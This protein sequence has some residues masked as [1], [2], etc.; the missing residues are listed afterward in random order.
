M[1]EA[2]FILSP[3]EQQ[4]FSHKGEGG[5]SESA[6]KMSL[7]YDFV[8]L[9]HPKAIYWL[10]KAALNGHTL[11]QYNLGHSYLYEDVVKD[12]VKAKYWLKKAAQKNYTSAILL[13][14]EFDNHRQPHQN[15]T[16]KTAHHSIKE[17]KG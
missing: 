11:A 15:R 10:K 5:D 8:A 17:H 14:K 3:A 2:R 12:K 7:Y 6:Y 9:D 4:E 1:G 16:H 13:L